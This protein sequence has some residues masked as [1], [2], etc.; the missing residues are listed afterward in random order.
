MRLRHTLQLDSFTALVAH[1]HLEIAQRWL[2]R[3]ARQPPTQTQLEAWTHLLT[4]QPTAW[5][6]HPEIAPWIGWL[7]IRAGQTNLLEG[8]LTPLSQQNPA[9]QALWAQWWLWQQQPLPALAELTHPPP[10]GSPVF[11]A[12]WWCSRAQ[13]LQA[14]GQPG[15]ESDFQLAQQDLTPQQLGWLYLHWAQHLTEHQQTVE[16]RGFLQQAW[17]LCRQ[18]PHLQSLIQYQLALTHL[19]LDPGL[20]EA[21]CL[22]AAQTGHQAQTILLLA[23]LRLQWGEW[24]RA[25]LAFE[26]AVYL[27]H[28]TPTRIQ[29]LYGLGESLFHL[30]RF[31]EAYV[32][33]QLM[34]QQYPQEIGDLKVWTAL[35]LLQIRDLGGAQQALVT[36]QPQ[37]PLHRALYQMG[38]AALAQQ[39]GQPFD[40]QVLDAHLPLLGHFLL[41]FPISGQQQA[42]RPA[43]YQIS[44]F[45]GERSRAL[46]NGR[47]IPLPPTSRVAELLVLLL[48]AGGQA[49]LDWLLDQMY[50]DAAPSQRSTATR[51]LWELV[52]QLR[53]IL[54]WQD[55]LQTLGGTYRLDPTAEWHCY[56][57]EDKLGHYL[58]Y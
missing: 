57:Q 43:P 36:A 38:L 39:R 42:T 29:A 46:V 22:Q 26:K 53:Q 31:D 2:H 32:H 7:L 49:N 27:A 23:Q 28:H 4:S 41:Q 54:G 9:A 55:S 25:L 35:C 58:D 11:H 19:A 21:H 20:S 16:A 33:F 18:D 37:T 12:L 40:I 56:G 6:L 45:A 48:E 44:V 13:A 30:R 15:A 17:P 3:L 5:R 14:T 8:Y 47:P 10:T 52:D 50:P 34:E 51:A 24:S 1:G